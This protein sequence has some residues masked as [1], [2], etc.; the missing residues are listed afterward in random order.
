MSTSER[1]ANRLFLILPLVI[2]GLLI[3]GYTALWFYGAGFMRDEVDK[4]IENEREA[5]HTVTYDGI[6]VRGYPMALRA[7]IDNFNWAQRGNFDWSG[8]ILHII[9]VPHDLETLILAPR[10]PQAIILG[11]EYLSLTPNNLRVGIAEDKYSAEGDDV[12][13]E[14]PEGPSLDL[15]SLKANWVSDEPDKWYLGASFRNVTYT[16]ETDRQ[17][18]LPGVDLLISHEPGQ[19]DKVT[20]EASQIAFDDGRDG[21][22]TLIKLDGTLGIDEAGYPAGRLD[23]TYRDEQKLLS[24]IRTFE[25]AEPNQ[26]LQAELVLKAYRS[27]KPEATVPFEMTGGA[28]YISGIARAKIGELPKIR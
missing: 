14:I 16:D 13:V 24:L 2:G 3:A 5:G 19:G 8:E 15:G 28:L 20:I 9:A 25:I 22:P 7:R 1:R 18:L 11:E 12:L 6:K 4:F 27:G 17:A 10:G 23:V 26:L 21:P